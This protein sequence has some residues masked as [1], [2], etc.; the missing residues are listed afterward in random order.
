MH[1]HKHTSACTH[2]HTC[3]HTHTHTH[4]CT[5]VQRVVS[6]DGKTY[7]FILGQK[8]MKSAPLL[9]LVPTTQRLL[10]V[11]T[12]QRHEAHG[13]ARCVQ[14][15]PSTQ[16]SHKGAHRSVVTVLILQVYVR[17]MQRSHKGAHRSVVTVLIRQVYIRRM[18]RSHKGAHRSVVTVLIWQV[19]I[20]EM[21][22][23]RKGVHRSVVT[24]FLILQIDV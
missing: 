6:T 18:Q 22:R 10:L 8:G 11:I 24:V 3:M 16:R 14:Q 2:T 7:P 4:A 20:T 5:H 13:L 17:R 12:D 15:P 23:S 1:E 19:Y 9:Q 21:Q